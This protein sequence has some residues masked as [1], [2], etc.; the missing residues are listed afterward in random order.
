MCTRTRA[1]ARCLAQDQ[2]LWSPGGLATERPVGRGPGSPASQRPDDQG[3]RR[4]KVVLAGGPAGF[5]EHPGP[6]AVPRALSPAENQTAGWH[7]SGAMGPARPFAFWGSGEGGL[8]AHPPGGGPGPPRARAPAVRSGEG[9]CAD[10]P[11]TR[12]LRGPGDHDASPWRGPQQRFW[13]EAHGRATLL[14]VVGSGTHLAWA[15]W[16]GK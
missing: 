5:R 2:R 9:T 13:R 12:E 11:E 15:Q 14:R 3:A 16:N 10:F 7:P 6:F 4:G 1:C 8:R